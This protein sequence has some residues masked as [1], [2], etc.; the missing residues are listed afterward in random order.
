MPPECNKSNTKFKRSYKACLN[1]RLRKVKCDL[2]SVDNP[3]E[4][5]CVRCMRERKDCVFIES[6]RGGTSNVSHGRKRKLEMVQGSSGVSTQDSTESSAEPSM[7]KIEEGEEDALDR[8]ETSPLSEMR[9]E[10]HSRSTTFSTAESALVFLAK[11][12]GT[13]AKADERDNIDARAKH[14]ELES[15]NRPQDASTGYND[16]GSMHLLQAKPHERGGTYSMMNARNGSA[17][18]LQDGTVN[19]SPASSY[20]VSY[21]PPKRLYVPAPENLDIVRPKILSSLSEVDYIGGSVSILSE[22]EAVYLIE[23]FF[24]FM[25]PFFPFIPKHLHSSH[26]LPQ[27]PILLCAILTLA[28]RYCPQD[29]LQTDSKNETPRNIEIHDRLWV[30]VQRLVSQSVWAEASSRS[31]GTV[32]A[33]LLFTEWNPRAVHWRWCDYANRHDDSCDKPS[34]QDEVNL[35]GLG[36]SRRSYRM[37]WMLTGAAVRLAQDLGLMEVSSKIMIATHTAE[38]NCCID[39]RKRSM[40]SQSITDIEID[41]ETLFNDDDLNEYAILNMTELEIQKYGEGR[42]LK[43][44]NIQKAKVEILQIMYLAH[45]SLYGPKAKLN[46]LDQ[47]QNLTV[48]NIISPLLN[49]WE[50]KY[51]ALLTP[52][53]MKSLE[54]LD[55]QSNFKNLSS[56]IRHDI[57]QF[58]DQESVILDFHYANLFIFSLALNPSSKNTDSSESERKKRKLDKNNL[59]LD[60]LSRSAK[61][62]ERAFN[63]A[64]ELLSVAH[65]IHNLKVLRCMTIRWLTRIVKAVAFIVK[66]Y[67][68]IVAHKNSSSHPA[69]DLSVSDDYDPTMLL[70]LISITDI[71]ASIHK[72]AITLRD[73]APD[74]LHICTRYSNILMYLCSQ[75]RSERGSGLNQT[76]SNQDYSGNASY[77]STEDGFSRKNS[78]SMGANNQIDDHVPPTAEY[79]TEAGLNNISTSTSNDL[80]KDPLR[81]E[82]IFEKLKDTEVIDWFMNNNN[83]VG[84]DFVGPWTEMIEQQLHLDDHFNFDMQ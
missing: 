81:E 71:A 76:A 29:D 24:I 25:H 2:G 31:I 82:N 21:N 11:A 13:I 84:L 55:L 17:I 80:S 23:F 3:R 70:S 43:L 5:K 19:G 72:A 60:E 52:P 79:A 50:K 20:S 42:P 35:A 54:F 8:Q 39:T 34:S 38:I 77:V 15:F 27:Y 47:I 49:N 51:K 9:N 22:R 62:I 53:D 32:L 4:G 67:S 69:S 45:E 44:T 46:G 7:S 78:D 10:S 48:L 56:K 66:C 28:A 57:A 26:I 40:L 75:M 58:I 30:Y 59:K 68:M 74:E 83:N 63:S 36:A 6:R 37:A 64:N 14:K 61:Y 65:R 16:G 73:N 18:S 33:F 1:C 12:A 41:E